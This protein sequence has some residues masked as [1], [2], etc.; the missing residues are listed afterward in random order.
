MFTQ[1]QWNERRIGVSSGF[2]FGKGV[3]VM[4]LLFAE[5]AP[6]GLPIFVTAD[7]RNL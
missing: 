5:P 1:H 7:T 2:D 3:E 6:I 4:S